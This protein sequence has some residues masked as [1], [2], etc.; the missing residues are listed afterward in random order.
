MFVQTYLILCFACVCFSANYDV[1]WDQNY[2]DNK[3]SYPSSYLLPHNSPCSLCFDDVITLRIISLSSDHYENFYRVPSEE[4]MMNCN[5]TVN[6]NTGV[7]SFKDMHQFVIQNAGSNPAFAFQFQTDP[8]YFISTSNGMQ[9]SA[10]SD[11]VQSP[12]SCLQFSFRV[13]L[14]SSPDCGMYDANCVFSSVFT[15]PISSLYCP[16]PTTPTTTSTT[17]PTTTTIVTTSATTAEAT[18]TTPN[19]MPV[20]NPTNNTSEQLR[21]IIFIHTTDPIWLIVILIII[22]VILILGI[23]VSSVLGVIFIVLYACDKFSFPCDKKCDFHPLSTVGSPLKSQQEEPVSPSNTKD[24]GE[25]GTFPSVIE[26]STRELIPPS[27]SKD[28]EQGLTSPYENL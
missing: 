10:Q 22:M 3:D 5:A 28:V 4:Q 13:F 20:L 17:I 6:D 12:N 1:I 16:P 23:P 11:L 25:S 9:S 27:N 14:S 8:F 19:P 7:T 15:D 2:C 21:I 24:V 26:S 18:T